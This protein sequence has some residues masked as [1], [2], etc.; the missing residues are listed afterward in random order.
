MRS[1]IYFSTILLL[2]LSSGATAVEP[3]W[4][5]KTHYRYE[6]VLGEKIF[7]REAG[8]SN[9]PVILL[10]H[11]Y[12]SSS[13]TYRELI[14]LLSGRYRVIAPDNLGS[15]FSDKPNPEEFDYDFDALACYLDGFVTQLGLDKFVLYMQDFGA[16]VGFRLM[17]KDPHRIEAMIVQNANAYLEGIPLAKQDF[18]NRA[19]T[20]Q[21]PENVTKLYAFTSA[22]AVKNQ[23]YLRDV[24]DRIEVMSPDTWTHDSYFLASDMERNIQVQLFQDYKTNLD[25]YPA[26]QQF[27]R[28]HQFPTL[29]VWGARDPV[30]TADGARAYL[31]DLPNAELHLL[32]AGHFAVEE[33]AI[34]I[35]K[36]ITSFLGDSTSSGTILKQ[37]NKPSIGLP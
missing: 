14:P 10:L 12:P 9:A 11:G 25:A 21:S 27:L 2:A 20:D 28:K 24:S 33:K 32:D 6:E 17:M 36:L 22:S 15:G 19:Q 23:Q 16:P 5:E 1:S 3:S 7:Y 29:I 35:A 26:W 18:F 13:H 4:P 34:Q 37:K 31:N 8:E 30:F